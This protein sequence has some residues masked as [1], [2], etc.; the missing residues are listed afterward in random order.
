MGYPLNDSSDLIP[1]DMLY[2]AAKMAARYVRY[3]GS[4]E[5]DFSRLL[6]KPI[7]GAFYY[8]VAKY[9]K[10]VISHGDKSVYSGWKIP[11]TLLAFPWIVKLFPDIKY[12]FWV[13]DPRD[14]IL[15]YHVTDDSED[16]NIPFENNK[17]D[18]VKKAASWKYQW[19]L[20]KATPKPKYLLYVKFEDFVL[21]QEEALKKIENF[22]NIPLSRIDVNPEAVG[23]WKKTNA[24]DKELDFLKPALSEL[25]YL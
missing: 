8:Y 19:D 10:S 23:R 1:H 12:I 21:K 7:E 14:I 18:I 22:L 11:E 17:S 16:F 6:Q 13:R 5:W 9:L 4:F 2:N 20:F 25:G 3:K 15:Q 24:I